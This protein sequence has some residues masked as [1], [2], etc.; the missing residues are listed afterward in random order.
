M[1]MLRF[2]RMAGATRS[3]PKCLHGILAVNTC[4]MRV[5][6]DRR[7]FVLTLREV[8]TGRPSRLRAKFVMVTHGILAGQYTLPQRGLDAGARF[9][10][11]VSLAGREGGRDCAVSITD[12]TGK[13]C[14]CRGDLLLV[15][16]LD[17]LLYQPPWSFAHKES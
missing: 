6:A 15:S 16:V 2:V 8:R 9:A 1:Q 7:R 5:R 17:P 11:T 10:G 14:S 13:V 3:V 12:L 4:A